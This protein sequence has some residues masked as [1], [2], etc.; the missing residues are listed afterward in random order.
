MDLSEFEKQLSQLKDRFFPSAEIRNLSRRLNAIKLRLH[1]TDEVFIDVYFNTDSGRLDFTT[2]KGERRV[3]GYDNAGGWH[4]HPVKDPNRH[5]SCSG[6][7]LEEIFQQTARVIQEI[8]R[9]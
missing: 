9:E 7:T 4:Y 6:P 8:A 3:F 1:I 5:D 2:I